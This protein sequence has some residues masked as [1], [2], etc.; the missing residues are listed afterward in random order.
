M[1]GKS[2]LHLSRGCVTRHRVLMAGRPD[3]HPGEFKTVA[4]HAGATTFVAPELLEGTLRAGWD[5]M[6]GIVD[7]FHRAVMLM[8]LITECH[9]FDDGNGR[10]ARI[11]TNTELVARAAQVVIA[12]CFRNNY[13]STLNGATYGNGIAALVAALDF[14]RRWVSAVNW[15]DWDLCRADLDASNAFEDPAV[16]EHSG[17]RLRLPHTSDDRATSRQT[18]RWGTTRPARARRPGVYSCRVVYFRPP[19]LD[20]LWGYGH[21]WA[22]GSAGEWRGISTLSRQCPAVPRTG[23][24]WARMRRSTGR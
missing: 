12:T 22:L 4:N 19:L 24:G 18:D 15:S 8:F 6:S 10:V 2:A 1:L 7:P 21:R 23:A 13:L 17:R 3:K 20:H 16:A 5:E 14:A 11:L 9:P